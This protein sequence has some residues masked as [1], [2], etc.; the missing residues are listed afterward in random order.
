MRKPAHHP[1]NFARYQDAP[2]KVTGEV[3]CLH[4]EA[5]ISGRRHL[6]HT[7]IHDLSDLLALTRGGCFTDIFGS[8]VA[9]PPISVS[10]SANIQENT[11]PKV[12]GISEKGRCRSGRNIP[13]KLVHKYRSEIKIWRALKRLT[14]GTFSFRHPILVIYGLISAIYGS[15]QPLISVSFA[16]PADLHNMYLL[17]TSTLEIEQ[18]GPYYG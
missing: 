3:Y 6:E 9:T 2:C 14:L 7:G 16:F 18:K 4:L 13:S 12:F 5:R 11:L 17:L 15:S 10:C 1:L 8:I